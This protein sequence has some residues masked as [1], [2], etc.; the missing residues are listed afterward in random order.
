MAFASSSGS[1]IDLR[2]PLYGEFPGGPSLVK[3]MA[4]GVLTAP[5]ATVL[6]RNPSLPQSWVKVRDRPSTACLLA[7]YPDMPTMPRTEAIEPRLT[8][9]TGGSFVPAD[10]ESL[11]C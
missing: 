3:S 2:A 5:G 9:L 4:I 11:T 7:T 6:T 8:M 10:R 1:N